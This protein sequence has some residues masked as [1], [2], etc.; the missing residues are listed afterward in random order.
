M[1]LLQR[2]ITED[3]QNTGI[4]ELEDIFNEEWKKDLAKDAQWIDDTLVWEDK[5]G[6]VRYMDEF[7]SSAK[8]ILK[9]DLVSSY[10]GNYLF[11]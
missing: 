6:D 2:C 1:S 7:G 4:V 8:L 5:D 9:E 10:I 3:C 11:L